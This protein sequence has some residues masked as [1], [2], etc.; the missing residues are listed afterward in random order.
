MSVRPFFLENSCMLVLERDFIRTKEFKMFAKMHRYENLLNEISKDFT[1]LWY[2]LCA[3]QLGNISSDDSIG[4]GCDDV[5]QFGIL[6]LICTEEEE[7]KKTS[8]FQRG[9]WC[10]HFYLPAPLSLCLC[11]TL[12]LSLTPV[13]SELC[14]LVWLKSYQGCDLCKSSA[15]HA[16]VLPFTAGWGLPTFHIEPFSVPGL[17]KWTK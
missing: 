1:E 15:L 10:L 3:F 2:L 7:E 9:K 11:H 13:M 4:T 17:D 14:E 16:P 12:P 8:Q 6:C 5:G